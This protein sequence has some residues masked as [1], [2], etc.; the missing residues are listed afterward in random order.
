MKITATKENLLNGIQTVQKAISNKN[1]IPVLSGIYLKAA[2]NKLCFRATD[3][4]IGIECKVP[5]NVIEEGEIVLPARHFSELVRKLPNTKIVITYN[6]DIIGVNIEYDEA[7]IDLKGWPGE[8]FPVMPDLEGE[9]GYELDPNV[10]KN[11]I[12]QII[13][14]TAADDSRPIF[15]GALFEVNHNDLTMVTT[16]THRLALRSGKINNNLEKGI[17]IIIPGKTLNEISRI[18]KEDDE[19]I[20]IRGNNNQISFEMNEARIISRIID[21][22]FPNYKQVIPQDYKTFVKVKTRSFQETVERANLFT[23]EKDGTS[24]IKIAINDSIL[25]VT[26]RSEIGKVDEKMPVY[27]EGEDLEISFNA[28]YLLDALKVMDAE[29]LNITLTGSLSPGIIKPGNNSN[30]L[31]L[32]LPLR[33]V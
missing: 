29:D 7:E 24:I 30:Y 16:D 12:K 27:V 14:A 19:I 21:G 26:S 31:Y 1:T 13:F 4:E 17:S 6:A 3:L 15:S 2:D 28:K 18:I 33:T 32:I 22:K 9:Y 8:E 10:L 23:N 20:K 5:V 25:Q 11:M